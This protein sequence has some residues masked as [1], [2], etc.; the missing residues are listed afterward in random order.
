ML[1]SSLV[2]TPQ[3][4]VLD[5]LEILKLEQTH[6]VVCIMPNTENTIPRQIIIQK[7]NEKN[8]K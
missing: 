1:D 3:T 5:A 4:A 7:R 2:V 6:S 8:W